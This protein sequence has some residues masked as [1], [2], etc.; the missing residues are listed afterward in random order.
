MNGTGT[1][2]GAVARQARLRPQATAV[3]CGADR[4]SY[5]E[6]DRRADAYA[7]ELISSGVR[8]G[9]MVPVLLPRSVDL[10][11]ALLAVLKCGAA[12]AVPDLRWPH[13]R[14]QDVIDQLDPPL[15]ITR[16]PMWDPGRVD[17]IR[18]A[19]D[20]EDAAATVFFTSGTTGRAKGVISPHR[21][22][23]RLF[24][25]PSVRL[26][27]GRTMPQVAPG[28]WDAFSLEL[29]G[30]LATGGT[31]V[32]VETDFLLPQHLRAL[33]VDTIF[34]TSALFEVAV[35][36][37]IDCFA[38]IATVL[39]GG[40]RMSQDHARRFLRRFPTSTL[41]NCYGPVETC[42]FVTAHRVRPED[43][44]AAGGVPVGLPMPHTE[45]HVLTRTG[46][47]AVGAIGEIGVSGHGLALG[48]LN[49]PALTRERF[50]TVEVDGLPRR[51]YRTGDLGQVTD[52][53][54][55]H[56]R[57]RLDRQVKIAGHRVEPAELEAVSMSVPGVRTSRVMP[58]L[59]EGG[60]RNGLALYYTADP[61]APAPAALRR[62]L[63]S[64]LPS[65]L[66]PHTVRRIDA[67]PFSATGKIDTEAL[68]EL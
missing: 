17:H 39:T 7:A 32:I 22:T 18:P 48:Y 37:D 25:Q 12:Y 34:L 19:P 62:Y 46:M 29:W 2:H 15:V 4:V 45:V 1:V 28:C 55:L 20:D 51:V 63:A 58:V 10:V 36:E 30:M 61:G 21:A 50:V 67:F 5:A 38:G 56:F 8:P 44:A 65:Y 42:V 33:T 23:M 6:L 47:A 31:S 16:P 52:Q 53:G 43:C 35:D 60:G 11:V 40:E 27:I 9:G 26:P 54:V 57:G 41:I 13:V 3:V 24:A 68:L 64:R 49:A 66:V 59:A 14:V